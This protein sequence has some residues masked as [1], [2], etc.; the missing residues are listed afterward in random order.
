MDDDAIPIHT[1]HVIQFRKTFPNAVFS[2]DYVKS[3]K[4]LKDGIYWQREGKPAWRLFEDDLLSQ[5]PAFAITNYINGGRETR[6]LVKKHWKTVCAK[7]KE[8]PWIVPTFYLDEIFIAIHQEA[9][10]VLLPYTTLFENV[11]WWASGKIYQLLR[12]KDIHRGI[13]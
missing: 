2:R 6:L 9:L 12:Y 10:P 11:T 5:N 3:D 13:G 8:M 4:G 7:R 1:D